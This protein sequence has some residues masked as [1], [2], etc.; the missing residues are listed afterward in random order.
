MTIDSVKATSPVVPVNTRT[1][2]SDATRAQATQNAQSSA[3]STTPD[4]IGAAVEQIQAHV[5][6][7]YP[8]SEFRVDYLSGLDVVTV[9]SGTGDVIR[10]IPSAQAVNLARLISQDGGSDVLAVLDATV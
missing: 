9:K 1:S 3:S 6:S 8:K 7:I 2:A 5:D 4:E 10:Q